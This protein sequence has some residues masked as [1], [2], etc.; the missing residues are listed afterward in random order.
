M[1]IR[2]KSQ[3]I[4][5]TAEEISAAITEIANNLDEQLDGTENM[6]ILAD[7]IP[8]KFNEVIKGF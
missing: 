7:E 4:N 3:D 8:A 1:D 2:D 5:A 6:I